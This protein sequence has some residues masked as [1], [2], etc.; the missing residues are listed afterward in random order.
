VRILLS[1]LLLFGCAPEAVDDPDP[2]DTYDTLAEAE[3]LAE[4]AW[5]R[6]EPADLSFD[7]SQAVLAW[8]IQRAHAASGNARHQDYYRTWLDAGLAE[9]FDEAGAQPFRSSDS[10]SP[11]VLA[12]LA[13]A[14]GAGDYAPMVDAAEVYLSEARRT[15]K[16]DA[17]VHWGVE[18][19][20]GAN[21]QV[22]VDSMFMIGMYLLAEADR[23]G[24]ASYVDRWQVQ[25]DGTRLHCK[26]PDDLYLHAWD[27]DVGV[28]IPDH[29]IYWARGNSWVLVSAAEALRRGVDWEGPYRAHA[30]ALSALQQPSGRWLTVLNGPDNDGLNYEE[31][32]A[33]ALIAY[34]L[35]VGIEEGVLDRS[36]YGPV[37]SAAV[38]GVLAQITLE[39]DGHHTLGGTSLGTNPG[40]YDYYVNIG[41]LP[42]QL[43]GVGAVIALLSE[44]HGAERTE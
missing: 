20:F 23:T 40:D 41:T 22:W 31:T 14:E 9:R 34:G 32:S 16:G 27:D 18:H 21:P 44:V 7:W 25:A 30:E 1:L 15:G 42:D 11:V 8:G 33:T 17:V 5:A 26:T 12:S 43:V 38:D 35:H 39:D 19:P 36:V 10:M 37:V 24:D 6:W 2:V 4:Q 13:M 3:L 29:A 28:N